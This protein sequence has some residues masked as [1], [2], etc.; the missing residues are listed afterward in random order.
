[1]LQDTQMLQRI[2]ENAGTGLYSI[3]TILP[4]S[5]DSHVTAELM[6][7]NSRLKNISDR[8]QQ[9]LQGRGVECQE[10]EIMS[11]MGI[12]TGIQ[13][14]TLLDQSASHIAEIVIQGNTMGITQMT[15]EL[16]S[17]SVISPEVRQLADE[18]VN[19]QRSNIEL[20]KSYL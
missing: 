7:Y 20:M 2:Y 3:Q 9:M 10:Q 4:K 11:K 15:T 5:T 19:I 12:W 13:M 17:S 8:A 14:N 16:N 1:M 18:F 6:S